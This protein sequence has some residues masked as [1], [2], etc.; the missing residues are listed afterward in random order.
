MCDPITLLTAGASIIGGIS[1]SG[2]DAAT[3]SAAAGNAAVAGK[4]ADVQTLGADTASQKAGF[5][6]ARLRTQVGQVLG[7]AKTYYAAHNL[8]PTFGSPLLIQGM[9]AA[10]GEVDAGL[11]RAEGANARAQQLAAAASTAAGGASSS[12]QAAAATEQSQND[13]IAGVFGAGTALLK[14]GATPWAGLS[15]GSSSGMIPAQQ[16]DEP[17]D[18]SSNS[19]RIS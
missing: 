10:Q 9:T 4:L 17:F 2:S 18:T 14:G 7:Q 6:E 8:D 11:V 1:K 3:A 5:D 15:L 13:L 16:W 19:F 12:W